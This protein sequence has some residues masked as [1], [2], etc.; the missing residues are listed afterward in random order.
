LELKPQHG[1]VENLGAIENLEGIIV[2]L[3][4]QKRYAPKTL[5]A[6]ANTRH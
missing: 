2:R 3:K 1:C 4:H 5:N 6:L